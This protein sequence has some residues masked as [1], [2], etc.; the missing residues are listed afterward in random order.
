MP[1][2]NPVILLLTFQNIPENFNNDIYEVSDTRSVC[3]AGYVAEHLGSSPLS[4]FNNNLCHVHATLSPSGLLDLQ[5][6]QPR[7]R[8]L[9]LGIRAEFESWLYQL[10]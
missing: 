4:L 10:E 2:F 5:E 9:G 1:S 8:C 3:T 6:A 7:G